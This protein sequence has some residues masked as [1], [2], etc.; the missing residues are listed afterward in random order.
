MKEW[1]REE[2][3]RLVGSTSTLEFVPYDAAY[4]PGFEDM[5]RRRPDI[6]KLQRLTGFS[7]RRSLTEIVHAVAAGNRTSRAGS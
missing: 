4:A 5:R 7:P 2:V 6:S 1:T 3:V